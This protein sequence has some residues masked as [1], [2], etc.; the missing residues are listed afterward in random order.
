MGY[1][2]LFHVVLGCARLFVG[3]DFLAIHLY[4][5]KHY[6]PCY[7][8]ILL[9]SE[10][11]LDSL[12]LYCLQSATCSVGKKMSLGSLSVDCLRPS[13]EIH[14]LELFALREGACLVVQKLW[15]LVALQEP[16]H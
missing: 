14:H 1:H 12:L 16:S 15:N 13:F 4:A 5:G 9:H 11:G 8:V 6:Y 10:S 7:F 3:L 2:C